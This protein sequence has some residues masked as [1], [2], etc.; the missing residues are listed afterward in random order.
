MQALTHQEIL[1][2][3]ENS[4]AVIVEDMLQVDTVNVLIGDSGLGKSPLLMQLGICVAL[5]IPF[6][7]LQT[8]CEPVLYIDYE[9]SMIDL[10]D[11]LSNLSTFFGRPLPD[12]F[13]VLHFPLDHLAIEKVI[14]E[15][16]PKLVI[17]DALR[18]FDPKAEME[19]AAMSVMLTRLHK[20]AVEY[21]CTFLILH[22]I[23]K[24][25][26]KTPPKALSEID[27]SF[28][29]WSL[30]ASGTRALVNQTEARFGIE[31]YTVGDASLIMRGFFKLK[32]EVGPWKIRRVFDSQESP[33]GY[34]RIVGFDL[35]NQ[36]QRDRFLKLPNKFTWADCESL[37]EMKP[38]KTLNTFIKSCRAAGLL[39]R[40]G[41]KKDGV[42]H[43]TQAGRAGV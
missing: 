38:G 1:S 20:I 42:Y 31:E 8:V 43:K 13:K 28:I 15:M 25:D 14:K 18:G 26:T 27:G 24:P 9:N 37:L 16:K 5:G 3:I 35:L 2:R 17:I 36:T 32:G 33:L 30:Q 19:S 29:A 10:G 39:Y 34:E 41:G 22:H 4:P 40:T 23:R 7:G 12:T 21:H 11:T 6:L